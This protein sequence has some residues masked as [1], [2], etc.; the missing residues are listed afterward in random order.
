[1]QIR[2]HR[3]QATLL[4]LAVGIVGMT[5]GVLADAAGLSLFKVAAMSALV[6]TGASQF[7]AVGVIAGGGSGPA[8][9]G[10]A[11]LLAARNALYGPVVARAVPDSV[12]GRLVASH[13]VIDETTAMSSMQESTEDAT[14]AF[15]FTSIALWTL[16]LLGSISGA[17]IGSVLG[18]PETLGL[19][20]AFPASFVAMIAP[21]LRTAP[22]RFVALCAAGLALA[23][24]PLTP[25]GV[26]LL[27]AAIAV[28]PGAELARRKSFNAG[29][30]ASD[31]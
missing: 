9:L 8:A 2:A 1:M 23:T 14:D 13:F 31:S 12:G 24:I 5:F 22:A 6:F 7:A 27:V 20:A 29:E 11:M 3:R 30:G 4:V 25:A 19:D 16:W 15:W 26:P 21:H 17:V 10:S 18:D 28:V